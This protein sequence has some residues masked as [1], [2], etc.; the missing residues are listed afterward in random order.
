MCVKLPRYTTLRKGSLPLLCYGYG[1]VTH[2]AC[3]RVRVCT[4]LRMHIQSAA[5]TIYLVLRP[6]PNLGGVSE[7]SF[8][9]IGGHNHENFDLKA[10]TGLGHRDWNTSVRTLGPRN[11]VLKHST[12]AVLSTQPKY[13]LRFPFMSITR[14]FTCSQSCAV[15]TDNHTVTL[16]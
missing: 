11:S 8:D 9:L 2:S 6:R 1:K 5:I 7:I 16:T 3:V 13:P 14:L 4:R 10:C 12:G 15:I